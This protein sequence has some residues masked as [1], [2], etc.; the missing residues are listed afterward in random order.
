MFFSLKYYINYILYQ[1]A[2]KVNT[3]S[4]ESFSTLRKK[5]AIKRLLL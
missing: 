5:A 4:Y 1:Y 2:S 3:A